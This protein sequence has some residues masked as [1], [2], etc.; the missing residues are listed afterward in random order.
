MKW[1]VLYSRPHHER[2][3]YE[4]LLNKVF[5]SYLPLA[6]V[7]RQSKGGPRKVLTPLFP[8][9]LFVLCRLEMYNHL[10]LITTPGVV[11]LLEDGPGQFLVV[12]DEE[13]HTLRGVCEAG[14]PF[15][16]APYQ[17][18]EFVEVVHGPLAGITGV[19]GKGRPRKLLVPMHALRQSVAVPIGRAQVIPVKDA[20]G[21]LRT[22]H[23]LE[24]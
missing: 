22:S 17:L 10:E 6:T 11:R 1:Y 13:I 16:R 24:G 18:G 19:I 9:H 3:V 5:D 15:E 4:R 23:S 12:P 2:A 8:R 20:Q 21:R 7:W 14:I